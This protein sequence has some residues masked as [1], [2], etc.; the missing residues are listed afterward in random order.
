MPHTL[1]CCEKLRVY[2]LIDLK[3]GFESLYLNLLL[4]GI[5]HCFKPNETLI[6]LLK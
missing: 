1:Y 5:G 4:K 2:A 3:Y 6:Y